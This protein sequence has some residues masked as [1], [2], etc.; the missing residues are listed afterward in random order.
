MILEVRP[1]RIAGAFA[2]PGSKSH[3]IRGIVAGL[4]ARGVTVLRHPLESADT[5]STLAAAEALGAEVV[6]F[7]DR[8]E[9][10]GTGGRLRDPGAVLD[11]GNS[12]TGLRLLAAAA[13][14]ADFPVGFDGDAS[15]RTRLMRPLLESLAMLGVNAES[16]DG[17]CPCRITG[18]LAGGRAS[19]RA[20]SSQFLTALLFACPYGKAESEIEVIELNEHRYVAIK[21]AW[22]DALGVVYECDSEMRR[23][24]VPGGQCFRAVDRVIPADFSTVAFPLGAAVLAGGEGCAVELCNLDFGD[25]QGD[26]AVF[27]YFERL[28]ARIEYS[29]SVVK[30]RRTG[31][32]RPAE[33]DLNATPDALP[34]M[35]AVMATI[36]GESRL[37]NVPQARIKETDRIAC[38]AVELAKMGAR[39]RELPDGL[40][41]EGGGLRGARL[42]GSG[43]HRSVMALAVAALAAE[44]GSEIA[45]AEAAGVTYPGFFDDF[46]KAGAVF[47]QK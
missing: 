15:L 28:G 46:V 11:L 22:L 41:I 24:R 40:V 30:V 47:S 35:A 6:C 27:E 23:F 26:K 33:I 3:T 18:P 20:V 4:L 21:L 45:G 7:A 16:N 8:W 19:V 37:V 2:V 44:G 1:S 43:D 39:V 32:L 12:G 38:M 34:L 25:C 29:G 36:P 14:L 13:A 42:D 10:T 5:A 17:K 31:N 9:I